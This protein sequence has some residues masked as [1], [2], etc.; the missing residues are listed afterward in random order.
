MPLVTSKKM[1]LDAREGH[2]AVG[3][4]N[5]DNM[6][7]AQG[8]I[9]AAEELHAPVMV[10]TTW[11]VLENYGSPE[12]FAGMIRPLAESSK[13]PVC[14]HLD[15]GNGFAAAVRCVKAGYSSVMVDGS[16]LPLPENI[17]I[18]KMTAEMA[19]AV[20]I[21]VEAELGRV[22]GQEDNVKADKPVYTDPEEAAEFAAK[23][24]IDSLA[25]GIGNAHGF[26]KGTPVLDVARLHE[27]RQKVEIPLVLH[28]SSGLSDEQVRAC[29][30]EGICKVNFA[31]ELRNAFCNGVRE[32]LES[33][34]DVSDPKKMLRNAR[35]KVK[36][37]VM[38]RIRV[39]G[40]DGKA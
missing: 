28:G 18:S 31:T 12:I 22:G 35:E 7:M 17:R 2:Y 3:A 19:H 9:S 38:Y 23:T 25:V 30:E 39:C 33:D 5:A 1:L 11:G 13:V 37:Q 29:I 10:Q 32:Y 15:H 14:L 20:G 27:I 24:G 36:E 21:P 6:E 40:C 4:F 34:P 8:I 26:Y 16:K